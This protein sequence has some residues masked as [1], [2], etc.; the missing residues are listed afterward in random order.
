M[1]KKLTDTKE[2]TTKDTKKNKNTNKKKKMTKTTRS[3]SVSKSI[4]P[5]PPKEV[6]S[7]ITKINERLDKAISMAPPTKNR[8]PEL[9]P[10]TAEYEK[11]RKNLRSLVASVKKYAETTKEMNAS[12][13]ELANNLGMFSQNS[14][15]YNHVG[16]GLDEKTTEALTQ[17]M[18]SFPVS[19]ESENSVQQ[20]MTKITKDENETIQNLV[21]IQ[22]FGTAHAAYNQQEYDNHV[23]TWSMEWERAVTERIDT[24]LQKVRKLQGDRDHYE[25]KVELLRKR[26]NDLES[27]GK[28]SPKGQVAKLERNEGKLKQAF[29]THEAEAGRLCTL[30]EAVTRDGWIEL[31]TLCRNYM[32][33]EANRVGREMDTYGQLPLVLDSM[34]AS[35][36]KSLPKQVGSVA[37]TTDSLK[38]SS[39]KK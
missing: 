30:L 36:K 31:Y 10:L 4:D 18:D 9:V 14:P 3:D 19:T 2:K 38:E 6:K 8:S 27:R 25:K 5:G 28:S 17:I 23:L 7:V 22:Q 39:V 35:Y 32:K 26:Y 37:S 11:M 33:W 15:I 20:L 16:S 34:K 12:R 29:V 13:A 1:E 21:A 24:D